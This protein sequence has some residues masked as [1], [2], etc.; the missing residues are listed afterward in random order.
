MGL[1]QGPT[2]LFHVHKNAANQ[3]SVANLVNTPV[4]FGT[5]ALNEGS[6]FDVATGRFNPL[7]RAFSFSA[8]VT[9]TTNIVTG[10]YGLARIYKNGSP[11][12]RGCPVL[13]T[14]SSIEHT[15]MV[16]LQ[17]RPALITDYYQ[18]YVIVSTSTAGIDTA[19]ISGGADQTFIQGCVF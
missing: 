6:Y 10:G 11:Y 16:E 18:V 12:K 9:L 13:V 14:S 17:E 1:Y 5:A 3:T 2:S 4:T 8:F 15:S 7:G 19:T